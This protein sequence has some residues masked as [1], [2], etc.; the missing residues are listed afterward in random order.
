MP[1]SRW[2]DVPEDALEACG[3]RVLTRS[4]EAGVD[5]F[6]KQ[7]KSLFV[8]FQGHPE[9]EAVT[10]LLEYRRDVGR[11]L[12]G[13]REAYPPMPG[14]YFDQDTVHVLTAMRQRLESDR[15]EE[16]LAEFPTAVLAGP[17]TNTWRSAAAAVYHNW[18]LCMCRQKE[19]R[20]RTRVS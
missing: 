12:R 15:R 17:L 18:L 2:N 19:G 20:M 11:F 16:L 6:V 7:R 13:E 10:L 8:F 5:T 1:H 14:G 4:D 3:Y 9:Y